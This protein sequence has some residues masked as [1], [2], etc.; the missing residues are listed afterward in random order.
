VKDIEFAQCRSLRLLLQRDSRLYEI[1]ICKIIVHN[2]RILI[3]VSWDSRVTVL[4]LFEFYAIEQATLY[5]YQPYQSCIWIFEFSGQEILRLRCPLIWL[6]LHILVHLID[7]R[8][9]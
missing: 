3:V 9:F 4:H 8:Y 7:N 2:E 5:E 1:R 6:I